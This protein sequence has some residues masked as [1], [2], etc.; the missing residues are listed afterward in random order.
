MS[1][2]KMNPNFLK[3]IENFKVEKCRKK[4]K[5]FLNKFNFFT[6]KLADIFRK[7][8]WKLSVN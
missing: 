4:F 2:L 8:F 1:L 3:K 5:Y 7:N 6:N